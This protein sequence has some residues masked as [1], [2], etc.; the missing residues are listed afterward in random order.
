[1]DL[2]EATLVRIR[3][4]PKAQ[5]VA[6]AAEAY[7]LK[8]PRVLAPAPSSHKNF[9]FK[10]TVVQISQD[11]IPEQW[12]ISA[13]E[14]RAN[15]PFPDRISLGRAPNADIILRFPFISKV[16]SHL[17][18]QSDGSW[19]LS[20]ND[21]AN[22]TKVNGVTLEAKQP[23]PLKFGDIIDFGGLRVELLSAEQIYD[24]LKSV[25]EKF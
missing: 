13:V 6:Q 16:H 25:N 21:S 7:L 8:K 19:Q 3:S 15:N 20:D 11:P 2:L 23:V 17:L 18:R 14:K 9:E 5:F 24:T 12:R 1:M 4:M 22:G 10:T